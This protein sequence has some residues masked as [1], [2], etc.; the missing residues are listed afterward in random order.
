MIS[1]PDTVST[2]TWYIIFR[3]VPVPNYIRNAT[4]Q[5]NDAPAAVCAGP[6]PQVL[7]LL[8]TGITA[9][10]LPAHTGS[11]P[12]AD[13][14]INF[15]VRGATTNHHKPPF[16]REGFKTEAPSGN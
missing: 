2:S 14:E 8:F 1:E 7:P 9:G 13:G 3:Y 6:H 15:Q 11:C 4:L 12:E 10:G 16:F 5:R